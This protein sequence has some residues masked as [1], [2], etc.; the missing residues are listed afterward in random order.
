MIN[1]EPK[2]YFESILLLT[3]ATILMIET[4]HLLVAAVMLVL[5]LLL[6]ILGRKKVVSK[7]SRTNIKEKQ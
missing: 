5:T 4:K 3:A 6:S 7:S 2:N 1:S